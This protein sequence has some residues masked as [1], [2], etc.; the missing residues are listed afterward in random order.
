[1]HTTG[2]ATILLN[3]IPGMRKGE[4]VRRVQANATLFGVDR[5][6]HSISLGDIVGKRAQQLFGTRPE[7][8]CRADYSYQQALRRLAQREALEQLARLPS[9]D[10]VLFDLPFTLSTEHGSVPDLVFHQ[11]EIQ[12]WHDARSIDHV[13]SLLDI[14]ERV[15]DRLVGTIYPNDATS[16]ADVNKILDWMVYDGLMA[17]SLAPY[18]HTTYNSAVPTLAIPRDEAEIT[19][20]KILHEDERGQRMHQDYPVVYLAGPISKLKEDQK[21][22]PK[23]RD[24]K[25]MLRAR[26]DR[27]QAKMQRYAITIVPMKIADARAHDATQIANTV[28]RDKHFFVTGATFTVAYYPSANKSYQS[29]GT[30]EELRH[31]LRLGKPAVLIH[32]GIKDGVTADGEVFGVRP[33]LCFRNQ[34]RFFDA[35]EEHGLLQSMKS[36]GAPRYDCMRDAMRVI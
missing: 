20:L 30:M 25:A 9:D 18:D 11:A 1:M 12:E 17:R 5:T 35:L 27:F 14:P 7:D 8:V 13:I 22:R 26:L 10:H 28:Y 23:V 15:A 21:D 31:G 6:I 24:E 32:P 36:E 29:A 3:G 34:T 33:R 19:L 4:L 16:N 2:M